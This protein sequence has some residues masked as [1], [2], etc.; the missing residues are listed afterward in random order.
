[1]ASTY[2]TRTFETATDR[3]KCTISFWIKKGFS[4]ETQQPFCSYYTA[5]YRLQFYFENDDKITIYNQDNGTDTVYLSSKAAYRD[6]NAWYHCY[7]AI[8]TTLATE[9]DRVKVYINGERYTDWNGTTT[10]PSQNSD[11]SYGST[12]YVHNIGRYGGGN[13]YVNGSLSH[14]YFV[15][16]SVID[17]SQFGS[18]DSTTGE[19]KISTSPTIAS[20]G[21]SGCKMFINDAS[22]DDQ[23]GNGNNFTLSGGTLTK[24]E[25]NPSN[26]FATWN[27]LMPNSITYSN[28]NTTCTNTAD[29]NYRNA[30]TTIATPTTGKFYA[31]FKAVSGFSAINKAIGYV[32]VEQTYDGDAHLEAYALEGSYGSN[33]RVSYNQTIDSSVPTFTDG[34]IIG[35]ALDLDNGKAYYHKN[36]T[37]INSGVPTSGSTG[38]GG[39]TMTTGKQYALASITINQGVA[40]VW[41][42]NFGNGYFGTTAVASAGTNASGIGIFEYDVPTGYTALSTKGLNE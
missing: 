7:A 41:S 40:N 8:D 27:P 42:A 28:G 1:M 23:S 13:H 14:Y 36:G 35:M 20:Y 37:Y 25:D 33:G 29:A 34:D 16:G 5:S 10:Y 12:A 19:W 26:I 31:E 21:N 38:T 6:C 22:V 39:Y 17:V 11:M 3:K 15:D 32:E 9:T 30:W 18:T 24:T 4:S 2:L